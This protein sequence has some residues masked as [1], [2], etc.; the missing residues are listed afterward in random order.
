MRLT[1]ALRLR[2]KE[3]LGQ[4]RDSTDSLDKEDTIVCVGDMASAR[5]IKDGFNPKV[6]VYDDLSQRKNIGIS[7]EIASYEAKEHKIENPAGTLQKDIIHLFR[8]IMQNNGKHKVFVDGEEDL[9]AL[10][11]IIEAPE[12][13]LVVYGQPNEGLVF[14]TVEKEIKEQVKRMIG[15]MENGD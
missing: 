4:V 7:D 6:I 10:A 15:E 9:T 1:S 13:S 5:I 14:V 2:L 8:N 11:A 12:G 3:P